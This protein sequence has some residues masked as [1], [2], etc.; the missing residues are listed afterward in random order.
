MT[1]NEDPTPDD[2]LAR[3]IFDW[4]DPER[5]GSGE[6]E[7]APESLASDD[8]E[9]W[10]RLISE[11]GKSTLPPL[12]KASPPPYDRVGPYRLLAP[13]GSGGFGHVYLGEAE[14]GTRVAVKLLRAEIAR[15]PRERERFQREATA[16]RRV[17]HPNCVR[18]LETGEIEDAKYIVFQVIEGENLDEYLRRLRAVGQRMT[19]ERALEIG[20][21]IC[22]A[23][24]AVHAEGLVHRDV[25]PGNI[26]LTKQGHAVL[27]DFG[28]ATG[29]S[30][31][32]LT[33]TGEFIGSLPYAPPEQIRDGVRE[34]GPRADIYSL[35]ATLYECLT[36]Q[37]VFTGASAEQ[38]VLSIVQDEPISPQRLNPA[39]S[40]ETAIVLSKALEKS[41]ARRYAVAGDFK[42]DLVAL[43]SGAPIVARPRSIVRTLELS[44]RK[45][46]VFS[47]CVALFAVVCVGLPL[48]LLVQQRSYNA[49]LREERDIAN[50]Q[51]LAALSRIEASVDPARSTLLALESI[52]RA[53]TM[54]GRTALFEGLS[55]LTEEKTYYGDWDR[56]AGAC[57]FDGDTRF[58]AL[59]RKGELFDIDR[60]SG[61]ATIVASGFPPFSVLSGTPNAVRIGLPNG[62][63]QRY[64]LPDLAKQETVEVGASPV[65][66]IVAMPSCERVL[67]L[68]GRELVVIENGA[69]VSR[70]KPHKGPVGGIAI[71]NDG[72]TLYSA[73]DDGAIR[74]IDVET[75]A[76]RD[77]ATIES[78]MPPKLALS[79][80][81]SRLACETETDV[82]VLDPHTGSALF[83]CDEDHR[84]LSVLAF[85]RDS[86]RLL[87]AEVVG[88]V[89]VMRT[90]DG[91]RVA[92]H[93]GHTNPVKSAA[94]LSDSHDVFTCG[95]ETDSTL[96]IFAER[97]VVEDMTIGRSGKDAVRVDELPNGAAL[98]VPSESDRR[99]DRIAI[100][101]S[102]IDWKLEFAA[103]ST[104]DAIALREGCEI[105]LL[106]HDS[107]DFDSRSA[108]DGH[109]VRSLPKIPK[110][111][112]PSFD[113]TGR[114]IVT[115][116]DGAIT[117]LD[118]IDGSV[119]AR[120]RLESASP[121]CRVFAAA[122][123][124]ILAGTEDGR[125]LLLDPKTLE[126]A[127]SIA[128]G[129]KAVCAAFYVDPKQDRFAARILST[130]GVGVRYEWYSSK[131]GSLLGRV[132]E[133][134]S[135]Y[136]TPFGL[137]RQG[138]LFLYSVGDTLHVVEL[139]TGNDR[140]IVGQVRITAATVS[141]DGRFAAIG[142]IDGA[143]RVVEFESG[144][145][146]LDI[147]SR[148]FRVEHLVFDTHDRSVAPSNSL[149]VVYDDGIVRRIDLLALKELARDRTPRVLTSGERDRFRVDASRN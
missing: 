11:S 40:R 110:L 111:L 84:Q 71:A 92:T 35:A 47:L 50:A 85:S 55:W 91:A 149:V 97:T 23:L 118:S 144:E 20:I 131:D 99:L 136:T 83:R 9:R 115:I 135:H 74:A 100:D 41:A 26:R 146:F 22:D 86:E 121:G 67:A 66:A 128:L 69:V 108:I 28:L 139:A 76:I 89:N 17:A 3:A 79:P 133:V 32:V 56:L 106:T 36:G 57:A 16:A 27:V 114:G 129:Q 15:D 60:A 113:A 98:L 48:A 75:Q 19:E 62:T 109:L 52:D 25:K 10:R 82:L 119:L 38:L 64:S 78:S 103:D 142:D 125:I 44:I 93:R 34:V 105:F 13:I 107:G 143:I 126:I 14:D 21:E 90:S 68:C 30:L 137:A 6:V 59:N 43:R 42:A 141:N 87:A 81:G 132:P 49:K 127:H 46:P 138:S 63:I 122:A 96:R 77:L 70:F 12:P 101:G 95:S 80:D 7:K 37:T 117:I 2:P 72:R 24:A 53:P 140:T 147:P 58:V 94:F 145:G 73:G 45:R 29:E 39:V 4:L 130:T 5:F 104:I 112:K 18:V 88:V 148:D 54:E 120:D 102:G 1:R 51:R 124:T 123:G 65:T 61:R 116:V 33:R 8:K 134:T 31:A